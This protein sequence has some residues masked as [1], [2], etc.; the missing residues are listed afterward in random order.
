ME[1]KSKDAQERDENESVEARTAK[2]I[3]ELLN[4]KYDPTWHCIVGKN[5]SMLFIHV[6]LSE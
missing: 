3:S 5:F 1:E 2:E 6:W 4:V